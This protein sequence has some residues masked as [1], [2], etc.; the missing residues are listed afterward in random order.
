MTRPLHLWVAPILFF[1]ILAL[2]GSPHLNP[3]ALEMGRVGAGFFGG[4][5]QGLS[6]THYPPLYPLLA[7]FFGLILSLPVALVA[8]NLGCVLGLIFCIQYGVAGEKPALW[9]ALVVAGVGLGLSPIRE[10]ALGADPRAVQMLLIF[11]GLF[12][13]QPG[14][15]RFQKRALGAL[16]ALLLMCRPEGLLFAGVLLAGAVWVWRKSALQTV[17]FFIALVFPYFLW[18][19][20]AVGSLGTR[21]WE[22]QGAGLLTDFPVRP[23]VQM[24]GAGAVDTPFRTLLQGVEGATALPNTGLFSALQAALVALSQGLS[25]LFLGLALWGAVVLWRRNRVRLVLFA[26]VFG[27]A[28]VLYWVPMGRDTAQPLLNLLPAVGVVW[29][30]ASLG[31]VEIADG[32]HKHF[33]WSRWAV[34]GVLVAPGS[35][36][37]LLSA[38]ATSSTGL[39]T[40]ASAWLK[41]NLQSKDRIASSLGSS[42]IVRRAE[43]RWER[44]PARWERPSLWAG[45]LQPDYLLLSSVDGGWM[46]GPPLL[47]VDLPLIPVAYFGDA[48]DWALLLDLKSAR[49]QMNQAA[50]DSKLLH[51]GNLL[52]QATGGLEEIQGQLPT[53]GTVRPKGVPLGHDAF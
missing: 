38:P 30:W 36:V 11:S 42:G 33:R 4:E 16:A 2:T 40:Q 44:V 41:Q 18:V 22:L 17:L 15:S 34:A 25:P 51:E 7:G 47:P 10:I 46:L 27:G 20:R 53:V 9:R 8:I 23:L 45:A 43:L 31:V 3:D 50:L 19:Y 28:L 5:T 52:H 32:V 26:C 1:L 37:D 39:S 12:L 48:R 13:L 29:V 24:W 14:A 35:T 21:S 6:W 49:R